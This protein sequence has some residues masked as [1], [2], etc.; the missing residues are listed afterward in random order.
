MTFLRKNIFV[1]F[2][3]F[4]IFLVIVVRFAEP[5]S[6]GDLF[7]QMAYGKYLLENRTL[8][9]DHSIYSWT[10]ADNSEI[11]CAWLSE[12]FFYLLFSLTGYT[13]IFVLRYLFVLLAVF[14][15]L[16]YAKKTGL[17]KNPLTYL[18]IALFLLSSH[19]GTEH[20]PELFSFLFFNISVWLY[21]DGKLD[22]SRLN[23]KGVPLYR[24]LYLLPLI[25]LVWVNSHG[26]FIF[27]LVF[28]F[29]ALAG[30]GINYILKSVE[31]KA[32]KKGKKS[33]HKG[34]NNLIFPVKHFL[35]SLLIASVSIFITPYGYKYPFML[36]KRI[37][38]HERDLDRAS[39][40]AYRSIFDPVNSASHY[41]EFFIFMVLI[42]II[43]FSI[44]FLRK[45]E[46]DFSLI[47][48][49][50][51]FGYIFTFF[52]RTTYFWPPIFVYT[53]LY[54]LR[55]F[56]WE[57]EKKRL[58]SASAV[59][60]TGCFLFISAR[61]IYESYCKPITNRWMGF[62]ISCQNPV[63]ETEFLKKYHP[64]KILFND[65]NTGGY[66]MWELYPDYKV[67]IDPRAFPYISWYP[68]YLRFVNGLDFKEFL[69]K[70]P[71]DTVLL[72]Y[73]YERCIWNFLA[74]PHWKTAFYGPSGVIF[75]RNEINLAEES[76]NFMPHR[77]DSLRNIG[78][79]SFAF[80]FAI[81]IEDYD[82]MSGIYDVIKKNFTCPAY[83]KILKNL[84]K[85]REA[86]LAY[87][88]GDYEKAIQAIEDCKRNDKAWDGYFLLKLYRMRSIE[89][90]EEGEYFVSFACEQAILQDNPGDSS[91]LF[92]AGISGYLAE[93]YEGIEG[94]P[95]RAY[96]EKYLQT[97]PEEEAKDMA[98]KV[99]KGNDSDLYLMDSNSEDLIFIRSE[100]HNFL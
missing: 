18:S 4:I 65:Y 37:F 64:G 16:F 62:G 34:K 44:S 48:L 33:T 30:E 67:S 43:V 6:D 97:E 42:L 36:I 100:F 45:K 83:G 75:V 53:I 66:L 85:H 95:W 2:M 80:I 81:N 41:G 86:F 32:G 7:F 52:M 74:S 68:E 25:M 87:K 29:L 17:E 50:L 3:V 78:N 94:I 10:P 47:F 20:K 5:V 99:L 46:V 39:V 54:L 13:G 59:F 15:I 19:T 49:N 31:R 1:I 60:L 21:F 38:S 92:N 72:S 57:E 82:G 24:K 63:A 12:I 8:I 9:P 55:D 70:Y 23:E 56:K 98:E 90:A 58:I 73:S 84:E 51:T 14:L 96:L 28:L 88:E 61:G 11:Y 40:S 89:K 27:G 71:C 77:F 93:R 76:F 79:A 35:L 22:V 26:A 69:E 91:A